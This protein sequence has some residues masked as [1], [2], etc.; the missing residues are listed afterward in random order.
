MGFE[1]DVPPASRQIFLGAG[2]QGPHSAPSWWLGP[3]AVSS[4]ARWLWGVLFGLLL[5]ATGRRSS[6]LIG[7]RAAIVVACGLYILAPG[8]GRGVG[9]VDRRAT[10]RRAIR[11][12]PRAF[13]GREGAILPVPR[14]RWGGCRVSLRST[15]TYAHGPASP[16]RPQAM[17]GAGDLPIT[18]E[19]QGLRHR[20][21]SGRPARRRRLPARPRASRPAR[22][23]SCSGRRP[24]RLRRGGSCRS[25]VRTRAGGRRRAVS[26]PGLAGG[27]NRTGSRLI[28]GLPPGRL[29]SPSP[30][31]RPRRT[32]EHF[33]LADR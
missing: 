16:P 8:A 30:G 20:G 2:F 22:R 33:R 25:A 21:E 31:G 4:T 9:R 7:V 5:S 1:R 23:R 29:H 12:T 3:A 15:P 6:Y 10:R 26:S 28:P 11:A 24:V 19:A 17:T 14:G 18:T 32:Q 27:R 13:R